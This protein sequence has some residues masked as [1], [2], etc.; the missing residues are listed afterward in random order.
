MDRAAAKKQITETCGVGW[1]TLVDIVYDNVPEG[2]EIK[3]VFQ[4]WGGLKVQ[5]DG[6]NIHFE[7]LVDNVYYISQKMCE[8]CGKSGGNTIMDG[9]ETTLCDQHYK[10]SD[11]KEKYR[12]A[13]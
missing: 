12:N 5:Y 1:L 9:W 10:E 6:E 13:K 2:I 8:V 4:K 11:A 3:E 7:E